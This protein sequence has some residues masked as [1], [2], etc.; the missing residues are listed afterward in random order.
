MLSQYYNPVTIIKTSNWYLELQN[1]LKN[2]GIKQ[3]VVITTNGNKER[4]ELEKKLNA[5]NI[6]TSFNNNQ[7][8][9]IVLK[10]SSFVKKI[11]MGLLQ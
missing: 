6:F 9:T 1:S 5:K 2:L 10:P 4:L 7:I 8:L 11:L 3:P